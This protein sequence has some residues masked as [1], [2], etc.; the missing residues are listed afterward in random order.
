MTW[1]RRNFRFRWTFASL[2]T[3]SIA[4]L[5]VAL[6]AVAT[7]RD[8]QSRQAIFEDGLRKQALVLADTLQKV[9]ADPLYNVDIDALNDMTELVR[10][11][12]NV[13]RI[14]VFTTDGKLLADSGPQDYIQ[15]QVDDFALGVLRAGTTSIRQNDDTLEVVGSVTDGQDVIGGFSVEID[16]SPIS[17]E[18]R[19]MTLRRV[20]EALLLV[21]A[22]AMASYL[23]AQYFVRPIKR[24]AR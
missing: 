18:I 14:Q 8:I 10:G 21:A 1:L 12:N 9:M 17:A 24:F 22:G 7:L 5:I 2:L 19:A 6:V 4:L 20:R 11:Q 23:I 15:G 13:E 16:S 3:L